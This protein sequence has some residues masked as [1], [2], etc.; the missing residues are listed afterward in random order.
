MTDNP[1]EFYKKATSLWEELQQRNNIHVDVIRFLIKVY[2][3][4]DDSFPNTLFIEHFNH[5]KL[6]TTKEILITLGFFNN[7]RR[8]DDYEFI[9]DKI[10]IPLFGRQFYYGYTLTIRPKNK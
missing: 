3:E 2:S 6:S 7:E 1:L 4:N 8:I 9:K 10:K 5:H